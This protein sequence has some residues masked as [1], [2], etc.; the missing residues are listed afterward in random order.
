ME[1]IVDLQ[2]KEISG[3]LSEIGLKVTL[4]DGA[5]VWLAK[6]GYDPS[7]GARPLRRALQKHVESPL[8]VRMLKGDFKAGDTVVA[9]HT[10]AEGIVFQR[11]EADAARKT[12]PARV[13]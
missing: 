1:R 4:T 11:L 10:E 2:M 12:E 5:R 7:F 3:R 9:D 13:A 8:S 6:E